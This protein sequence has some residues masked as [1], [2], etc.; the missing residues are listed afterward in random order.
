MQGFIF[1]SNV[2]CTRDWH[3]VVVC[4][5]SQDAFGIETW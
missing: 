4:I 3:Q 2:L 5:A 1:D